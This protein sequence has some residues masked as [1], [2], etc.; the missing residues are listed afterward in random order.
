MRPFSL[1]DG[2]K[3][4][5]RF[6]FKTGSKLYRLFRLMQVDPTTKSRSPLDLTGL[7]MY[8]EAMDGDGQI[9]AQLDVEK[10]DQQV[11]PGYFALVFLQDTSNWPLGFVK[12]DILINDVHTMTLEFEIER[13][14]TRKPTP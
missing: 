9:F 13:G 1:D 5:Q 6:I 11:Q 7:E 2:M 14:I 8:C 12:T 4:Q 3:I 10:L